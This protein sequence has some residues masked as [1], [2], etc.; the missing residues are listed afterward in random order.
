MKIA[1]KPAPLT[2]DNMPKFIL[3]ARDADAVRAAGRAAGAMAALFASLT[4]TDLLRRAMLVPNCAEWLDGL[5]S[6]AIQLR[7]SLSVKLD[8]AASLLKAD[9]A[10]RHR[11]DGAAAAIAND[12]MEVIAANRRTAETAE[13][14]LDLLRKELALAGLAAAEIDTVVEARAAGGD[15]HLAERRS[16]QGALAA[17]ERVR[18]T[19]STFLADP[20]RRLEQLSPDARAALDERVTIH[21]QRRADAPTPS[22]TPNSKFGLK[23]PVRQ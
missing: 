12:A 20:L 17:A 16:A 1:I 21:E 2:P 4:P 8:E 18:D 6:A 11:F 19:F 14:G 15:G 9:H 5:A 23:A 22:R 3:I 10:E 7:S 13:A